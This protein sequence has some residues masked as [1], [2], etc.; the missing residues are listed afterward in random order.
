MFYKNV[1]YFTRDRNCFFL[2][3]YVIDDL[4]NFPNQIQTKK[5]K[6]YNKIF[7]TLKKNSYRLLIITK[8]YL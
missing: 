2:Y 8:Y 3:M 5:K 4:K 6:N 1:H 7:K